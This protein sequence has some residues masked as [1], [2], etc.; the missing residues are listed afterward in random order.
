MS[1]H[2]PGGHSTPQAPQLN[3]SIQ[4][5]AHPY[6]QSLKPS[7]HFDPGSHLPPMQISP[8]AH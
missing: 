4:M 2:A 3:G 5:S 7:G 8:E 1:H 6:G